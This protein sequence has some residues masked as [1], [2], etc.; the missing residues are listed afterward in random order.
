MSI[1]RKAKNFILRAYTIKK[2]LST[3][4]EAVEKELLTS[5]FARY[6]HKPLMALT[7]DGRRYAENMQRNR[8]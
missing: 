1:S 7:Y 5:G 3:V 8:R 6:T 2:D 4:D